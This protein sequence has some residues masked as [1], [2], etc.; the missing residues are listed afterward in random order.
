M[1]WLLWYVHVCTM[2]FCANTWQNADTR[3]N[4][5]VTEADRSSESPLV[6]IARDVMTRKLLPKVE[7]KKGSDTRVPWLPDGKSGVSI[8][9]ETGQPGRRPVRKHD[10]SEALC[11][12]NKPAKENYSFRHWEGTDIRRLGFPGS[13]SRSGN[14]SLGSS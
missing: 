11:H 7:T 6:A 14:E 12:R 5:K 4:K 13:S 8:L 2:I 1:L 9:S 10:H 3:V